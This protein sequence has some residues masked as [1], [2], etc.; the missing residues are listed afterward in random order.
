MDFE[1]ASSMWQAAICLGAAMLLIGSRLIRLE[2]Q[3][4]HL[5]LRTVTVLFLAAAVV[6]LVVVVNVS[7]AELVSVLRHLLSSIAV[8]AFCCYLTLRRARS[9]LGA[10]RDFRS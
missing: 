4:T 2:N 1:F 10:N 7:G 8:V 9:S 5:I 3:G 6:G